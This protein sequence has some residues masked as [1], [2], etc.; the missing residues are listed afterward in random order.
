MPTIEINLDQLL[1]LAD[2]PIVAGWFL[3]AH[4][5]WVVLLAF[6]LWMAKWLWMINI[7][8]GFIAKK[9]NP[10]LLAI[11]VPKL[12]VQTAKGVENIFSHLAGAHGSHNRREKYWHGNVQEWFSFEIISI[13]GYTQFLVWT[14]D[15]FRDLIETAIYAQYP[16]AQITEV[17]DYT[18]AV[19]MQYPHPEWELFGTEFVLTKPSPYPLRTW[20]EFE[21]KG[22]KDEPFKDPLAALLE[23]LARI[24]PGE[25]IW[26]QILIMPVEQSWQKEGEKLVKKLIGAKVQA[27]RT[28]LDTA[29][30]A[31]GAITGP[32][33]DQVFGPSE[34]APKRDEPPSKVLYMS[35]GER[36]VAEAVEK[37]IAKIGFRVK[38][39]TIYAARKDVFKKPRGAHAVIGSIK[40]FNTNDMN[41]LKPEYKHIAPSSLFWF[42][43]RRNDARRRK[44]IRAYR[45]RSM[46]VGMPAY[47]LNIEELATLWHFPTVAVHAPLVR[48]IEAKRAQPPTGLPVTSV[49]SPA[50]GPVVL[51]PPE[52]LPFV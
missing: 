50:P 9:L 29:F 40:Q 8:L 44:V 49:S 32:I 2:D 12:T 24:G 15:K 19:P 4:G 5:G 13:E 21:H 46:W 52:G 42:K 47:I 23:N 20:E 3:I 25:Q 36:L 10:V 22:Q 33:I 43:N 11:D 7:N 14:W 6:F 48:T 17:Q 51:K 30:E 27:P 18:T 39:R 38:I 45:N 34:V 41:A 37:K 16:D 1:A 31:T 26:L 35:A 28:I